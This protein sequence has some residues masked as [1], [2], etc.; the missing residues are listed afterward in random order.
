MFTPRQAAALGLVALLPVA[1]YVVYR[2]DVS[3]AIALVNV[4]LIT[5]S[6]FVAFS[7]LVSDDGGVGS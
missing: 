4:V 7:P 2:P 5:A 3:A 6:L 1:T